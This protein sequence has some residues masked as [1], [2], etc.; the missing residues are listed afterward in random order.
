MLCEDRGLAKARGASEPSFSWL[1]SWDQRQ[2]LLME[3]VLPE[4]LGQGSATSM[5]SE[6]ITIKQHHTNSGGHDIVIFF[7]FFHTGTHKHP[8]TCTHNTLGLVSFLKETKCLIRFNS[9]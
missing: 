8:S 1:P 2:L 5:A 6:T 4:T 3:N 9:K 7:F